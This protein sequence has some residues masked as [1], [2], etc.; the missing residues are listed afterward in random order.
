MLPRLSTPVN[1]L[2]V[3]S[4]SCKAPGVRRHI[5]LAASLLVLRRS[6]VT[7]PCDSHVERFTVIHCI[8]HHFS[9]MFSHW[10]ISLTSHSLLLL[11]MLSSLLFS[12]YIIVPILGFD[13]TLESRAVRGPRDTHRIEQTTK[14]GSNSFQSSY[15]MNISR[16]NSLSPCYCLNDYH[17]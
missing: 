10:W 3:R 4:G 8:N 11:F 12:F 2:T 15:N 17:D 5:R 13:V 6:T 14:Q 1:D 16:C 7:E 9:P